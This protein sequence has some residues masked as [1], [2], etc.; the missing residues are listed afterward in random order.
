MSEAEDCTSTLA[1]VKGEIRQTLETS[2]GCFLLSYYLSHNSAKEIT[3][4]S[5][6]VT[7]T[8]IGTETE[9]F[10]SMRFSWK[11]IPLVNL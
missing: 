6:S 11:K 5:W 8:N 3:P 2:T 7:V 9:W 1:A 4:Y 10:G